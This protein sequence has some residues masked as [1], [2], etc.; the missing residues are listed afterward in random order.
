MESSPAGIRDVLAIPDFRRLWTALSLSSLGDW[1]GLLAQSSLAVSLAGGGYAGRS[2]AV[3]GVFVVRLIPAVLFGPIAG[4][5]ADRLDRRWTMVAGDSARC[6]FFISIPL[7]GSLWWLFTATFLIEIAAMFWIPAK[8]ATVPNLVPPRLLEPANQV[9]LL[10][11]YGTA[12]IAAGVFTVLSLIT[13]G[14]ASQWNFFTAKPVSLALY[15]D[16]LTFLFSALTIARLKS[17]PAR[18]AT[19]RAAERRHTTDTRSPL[20]TLFDGWHYLGEDKRIRGVII[21]TTGAFAAGGAV[22]GLA[23]TY[24]GDLHAGQAAYGVLFGTVFLGLAA[25]MFSGSRVLAGVSRQRLFGSVIFAAG[26][27]LCVFALVPVLLISVLCALVIGF[28]GGTAWIIGQTMLGREVADELRGRTFAFVQSLIRVTLVLILAVSPAV[29][30]MFGAHTLSVPGASITYGGAAITLF[31]AGLLAMGVGWVAYRMMDDVPG[32][33]LRNELKAALKRTAAPTRAGGVAESGTT[34]GPAAGAD[35]NPLPEGT[36]IERPAHTYTGTFLSFEGG[37]G[38]GKSTQLDLLADWL[39]GRGHE[40]VVT[41]EPGGTPLGTKLRNIVLDAHNADVISPRAEA[42]IYA[43]DRAD[44]V[45]RVVRPALERGAVVITDRYVDSSLAYQG[46]GRALSAREV[47][48]LSHWATQG[49]MP[50]VTVLMD[51]DPIEAA[52]RRK[53]PADRLELESV[54]FHRRVRNRYLELAAAEPER[55]IVINALETIEQISGRIKARLDGRIHLSRQ[56]MTEEAARREEERRKAAQERAV[57]MAE[58]SD[59]ERRRAEAEAEQQDQAQREQDAREFAR[60]ENMR[61]L[62]EEAA[63]AERAAR[64]R[65]QGAGSSELSSRLAPTDRPATRPEQTMDS[66]APSTRAVTP[67]PKPTPP[68]TTPRAEEISAPP[69][70]SE[71]EVPDYITKP[72]FDEEPEQDA[73]SMADELFGARQPSRHGGD[74]A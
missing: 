35:G 53:T 26:L 15:F 69:V 14:L 7:V 27:V 50:D 11:A 20:R 57:Q 59:A 25:G 56:Q 12:P 10:T 6:L 17:I 47:E 49:L 42:L 8:E 52:R 63:K 21:G 3:A 55:F 72:E 36:G 58:L 66:Y 31:G 39:R 5:V 22:V 32:K 54:D 18:S 37:D 71:W 64:E 73:L 28:L 51:L 1:L 16:A 70:L 24:V 74:D 30:G 33:S 9:S 45:E 62:E 38:S 61:R 44:H 40:V 60:Q 13:R 41:R 29:A 67:T 43:A 68:S 23:R 4:V 34:S 48:L 19:E 46:A 2:Y 65:A